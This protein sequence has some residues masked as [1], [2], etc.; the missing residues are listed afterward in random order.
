MARRRDPM[1]GSGGGGLPGDPNTAPTR[2]H[3]RL[4]ANGHLDTLAST[5]AV[6]SHRR[7]PLLLPLLAGEFAHAP[8]RVSPEE[9]QK[10]LPV[11]IA[12]LNKPDEHVHFGAGSSR[13]R[14]SWPSRRIDSPSSTTNVGTAELQGAAKP[15]QCTYTAFFGI[16]L[17][18]SSAASFGETAA[19]FMCSYCCFLF[20]SPFRRSPTSS[21]FP[22]FSTAH[23]HW[24]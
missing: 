3:F 21:V 11:A 15:R 10:A 2:L 18:L 6:A 23:C 20:A 9:E 12:L 5:R 7:P 14:S 1:G 24:V 16:R 19:F 4:H 13:S 17:L 22:A 8:P